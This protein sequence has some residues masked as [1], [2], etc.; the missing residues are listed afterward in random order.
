MS[1]NSI[2]LYHNVMPENLNLS[3]HR[4]YVK[5]IPLHW[6]NFIEIE[7]VLEGSADNTHNGISST[8]KRGH[9]SVLR[10][11]DY[12]AIKNSNNL[13]I[14]NLS[15]KDNAI[16]EKMLSQLNSVQGIIALDLDENT[17]NRVLFFCEAAIKENHSSQRNDDYIQNLLECVLILLLR[18][19]PKQSK[20]I[21]KYQNDQLNYAVNYLHNHFRD[22]PSLNTIAKIAHY[23]P[24][25]FSHVFHKKIGRSYNDYLNDLKISYSKQLLTTTDLKIIDA[26][27]QSGFTSYNNFYSTFKNYTGVS[28][29]EYKKKKTSNSLPQSNSWRFDLQIADIAAEPAYMYIDTDILD[30]ETE[31]VFSYQYTYDHILEPQKIQNNITKQT[32]GINSQSNIDLNKKRKTNKVEISFKTKGKAPYRIILK[33]G[34]GGSD[35]ANKHCYTT[36]SALTLFKA[37]EQNGNVNYAKDYS[38]SSGNISWSDNSNAYDAYIDVK[39]EK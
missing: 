33:M 19:T 17:F 15:I 34:K 4:S 32:I 6:H 30:P 14:L 8:I 20:S 1:D 37:D 23:S 25:H 26:G 5:D 31:Y 2:Y 21:K 27:F 28:P 29:A 9:V 12:H 35:I 13:R 7:L 22:N 16:S 38:H 18:L 3:Y 36:V 24:T 39:I 10:I 11:N